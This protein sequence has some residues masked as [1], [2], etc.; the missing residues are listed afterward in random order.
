MSTVKQKAAALTA[1]SRQPQKLIKSYKQPECLSSTIDQLLAGLLFGLQYPHL[2]SP[3]RATVLDAIDGL[4]RLKIDIR[5]G[6]EV[7]RAV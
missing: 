3:E 5:Q 6:K 1:T 7:R 2:S 4:L